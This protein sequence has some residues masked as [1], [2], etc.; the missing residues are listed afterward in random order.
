MG[1][2]RTFMAIS[3][4]VAHAAFPLPWFGGF[5]AQAAVNAFYVVSGFYMALV[6]NEKYTRPIDNV[7]FWINR[8]IHLYPKFL[9]G[10]GLAI[11]LNVLWF[12]DPTR[13]VFQSLSRAG[14]AYYIF[15]NVTMI[16]LDWTRFV[17][18]PM[19]GAS[20]VHPD[21]VN[22]N[23]PSWTISTEI[24]FYIAAPFMLRNVRLVAVFLA[25][26]V[27]YLWAVDQLN[28]LIN[29]LPNASERPTP[30]DLRYYAFPA[31]FMF[32]GLGALAYHWRG[33][34]KPTLNWYLCCIGMV[35]VMMQI[36]SYLSW[37]A[38]IIIASALPTLFTLTQASRV[39]RI[40]GELSYPIYILHY[41][42][43]HF[44]KLKY[45]IGQWTTSMALLITV[46]LSVLV[47]VFIERPVDRFRARA[48]SR[49]FSASV[50]P[51]LISKFQNWLKPIY[52]TYY[53]F[54]PTV[55]L[56]YECLQ[57]ALPLQAINVS[58]CPVS[59]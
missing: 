20:C 24:A 9:V 4:L 55:F 15:S 28:Y 27:V 41:P 38:A 32:F 39:D 42:I 49:T 29:F 5:G 59:S 25:L 45:G 21:L 14:A 33:G 58:V 17:C 7:T 31:S 54:L 37:W 10:L 18:F 6:L 13:G 30:H 19:N 46:V 8:Y 50:H 57:P 53:L 34:I 11:A 3:V 12:G 35:G 43:V 51:T 52:A 16:G 2:L 56:V 36:N 47:Y 48:F 40:I 26:G 1:F 22:I 23:V 44:L